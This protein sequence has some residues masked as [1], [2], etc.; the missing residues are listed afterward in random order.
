MIKVLFLCHGS[1]LLFSKNVGKS[2]VVGVRERIFIP[3]LSRKIEDLG[4]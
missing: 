4:L 3:D 1:K 2:R